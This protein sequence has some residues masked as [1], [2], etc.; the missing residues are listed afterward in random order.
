MITVIT[1]TYNR[2][3]LLEQLY[4]SLLKNYET[5]QKFE[6]L[7]VDDGSNDN[8]AKVVN[9]WKKTAPFKIHYYYQSNQGKMKAI[10]FA[11]SKVTTELI[12]EVDSDDFLT[13]TALKEII[14]DYKK[15]KTETFY[16]L[17]YIKTMEDYNNENFVI[18]DNV[19]K[20]FDIYMKQEFVGELALVYK[21]EVR[22]KYEHKLEGKE[23]FTTEARLYNE[24]DKHEKGIILKDSN[25]MICEYQTDGYTNN[26]DNLFKKNPKGYYKYFLE[27][28]HMDLT[29]LKFNKKLYLIKHLILFACLNNKTKKE[30][31]KDISKLKL[32]IKIL[33]SI[34]FKVGYIKTRKRFKI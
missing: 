1:P 21:A 11:T 30:V 2:E 5:F 31:N 27:S 3:K 25:I 18:D 33:I 29:A 17:G 13:D 9:K 16:A 19:N 8:T 20:M 12:L 4:N 34:L 14:K 32:S 23:R 24:M 22:K 28:L 15:H 6:W 10:N 26:I 7:I